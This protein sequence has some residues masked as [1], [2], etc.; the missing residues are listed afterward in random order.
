MIPKPLRC[1]GKAMLQAL[2]DRLQARKTLQALERHPTYSVAIGYLRDTLNDISQGLGQYA[3]QET[4]GV[5]TSQMINEVTKIITSPDPIA[6]NRH[7]VCNMVIDM[8]RWQ[9]LV[10]PP[11]SE[12]PNDPTKLRGRP[13][14]TGE[15]YS[16]LEQIAKVDKD[17]K[18]LACKVGCEGL[19]EL[20]DTILLRYWRAVLNANVI[21]RVR[22]Q[23]GDCHS[24]SEKDWFRPFVE[25]MCAVEEARYRKQLGLPDVL[26]QSDSYGDIAP[27]KY[28]TFMNFVLDPACKFP[29]LAWE[30]HY[31]APSSARVSR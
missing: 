7:E 22:I 4:K 12:Q 5:I 27:L 8:A 19:D 16:H 26:T 1:R 23:L 17:V 29:N 18:E 30:D 6:A 14:I 13:G 3:D 21:N 20:K 9:V 2:R 11:A 10:L 28:S 24:I 25:A 15:L 31:Q